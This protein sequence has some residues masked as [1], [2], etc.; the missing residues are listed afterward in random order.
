MSNFGGPHII[1][2]L[3]TLLGIRPGMNVS[4]LHPP[5]G[6]FELLGPLP[7]GCAL[8]DSSKRGIDLTVFFTTKKTH[9]IEKLE[10]LVQRMSVTGS[11]WIIFPFG[12]EGRQVP[13]DDFVRLACLEAGLVDVK[14]LMLDPKWLG[15]KFQWKPKGP[16][17]DLPQATA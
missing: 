12:V 15:L 10:G 16:R 3:A 5:E 14:Q 13:G 2:P 8:T 4:V 6:F 1:G 17:L 9:L 7:E 11:V